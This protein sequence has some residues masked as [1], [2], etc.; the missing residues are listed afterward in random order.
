MSV[1]L[2]KDGIAR[3]HFV[4]TLVLEAFVSPR[5]PG[6]EALHRDGQGT[7]NAAGNLRWGTHAE[8]VQDA[9]RHGVHVAHPGSRN[10]RSILTEADIPIIRERLKNEFP[11]SIAR[12]Y[13]VNRSTIQQIKR[14]QNWSHIPSANDNRQTS[15]A[16]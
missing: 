12:D 7:N 8:N 1:S 14:G 16:A 6:L 4:H 10:G 2:S 3:K 9:L 5:P 11:A 13:G 15:E